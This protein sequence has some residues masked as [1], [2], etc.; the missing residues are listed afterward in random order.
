M[1]TKG[2]LNTL[3]IDGMN[4]VT[5]GGVSGFGI[6]IFSGP[7]KLADYYEIFASPSKTDTW[8]VTVTLVN[9]N[10]D[11]PPNVGKSFSGI[12]QIGKEEQYTLATSGCTKGN[13]FATCLITLGSK[14]GQ[15]MG[16]YH[17]DRWAFF[18]IAN[19]FN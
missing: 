14:Y 16:L 10:S 17:H 18:R 8:K 5:S 15:A 9:L 11:Q 4:Y 12:L 19:N 3:A 2:I 1:I 13:N 6:T 7:I